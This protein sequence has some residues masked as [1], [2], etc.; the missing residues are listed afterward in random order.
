MFFWLILSFDLL[1]AERL[2]SYVFWDATCSHLSDDIIVP[3]QQTFHEL[4][5]NEFGETLGC[6]HSR[7]YRLNQGPFYV[8]LF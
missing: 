3:Q 7:V 6:A 4:Y 2:E 5:L 1:S 8:I